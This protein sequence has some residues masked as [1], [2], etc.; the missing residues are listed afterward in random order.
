MCAKPLHDA[1][2]NLSEELVYQ[3]RHYEPDGI[4]LSVCPVRPIRPEGPLLLVPCRCPAGGALGGALCS[5]IRPSEIRE[6]TRRRS[7]GAASFGIGRASS[8][9]PQFLQKRS[10]KPCRILV[11]RRRPQFKRSAPGCPVV[12]AQ[13]VGKF[14]HGD[15]P[16]AI[17]GVRDG[18]KPFPQ[19]QM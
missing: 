17:S 16:R 6:R 7:R 9:A 10:Q 8:R 5:W 1:G 2:R 14:V 4:W 15:W 3:V 18:Q 13:A 12:N 19:W 11:L